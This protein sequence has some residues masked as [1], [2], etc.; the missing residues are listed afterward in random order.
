MNNTLAL[1]YS[2]SIFSHLKIF[3]F[4]NLK[5][6]LILSLILI[7]FLT[8]FYIIKVASLAGEIHIF[9]SYKDELGLLSRENKMLEITSFQ[10]NSLE[11]IETLVKEMGFE[12]IGRVHYIQILTSPVVAK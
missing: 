7:P 10:T 12:K 9:Q 8:A 1:N 4:L 11:N 3:K 2:S 6:F 5:L